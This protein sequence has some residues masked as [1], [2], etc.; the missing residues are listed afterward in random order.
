MMGRVECK[1]RVGIR[2]DVPGTREW[3]REG[4]ARIEAEI[5][6][7]RSM[8]RDKEVVEGKAGSI[9]HPGGGGRSG[10]IA[11]QEYDA[12]PQKVEYE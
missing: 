5:R 11:G 4:R 6:A 9:S 8:L 12:L 2:V 3:S 1:A 10:Y 7:E